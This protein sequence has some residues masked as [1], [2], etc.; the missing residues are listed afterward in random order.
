MT[1]QLKKYLFPDHG[2]RVQAVRLTGA[3]QTGLAH[4][5]HPACVVTLLGE[6]VSAA[7]LLASNIKF[8]GSVILQLQGEGPVALMVV[9]CT[10]DDRKSVL[11][12]KR[13]AVGVDL[14]GGGSI[15]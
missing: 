5:S 13:V 4:Q 8:D 2:T 6:L 7:T 1:D 12:G 9:E 14:G 3:W 11:W 15:K 10:A